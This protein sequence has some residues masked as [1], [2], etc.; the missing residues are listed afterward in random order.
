[1]SSLRAARLLVAAL[2]LGP[3]VAAC[4]GAANSH[5]VITQSTDAPLDKDHK[6]H[7][8]PGT[9]ATITVSIRNT[10]RDPARGVSIRNVLPSGFHYYSLTTLGGNAIRTS[11][12]DPALKGD[13]EWGVFTIPAGNTSRE[14]QLVVSFKV[15]AAS[16]P[17]EY[18]NAVKISSPL[19]VDLEKG[20]PV[21]LIVEPRPSLNLTTASAVAQATS[22]GTV[23]YLVSVE[24]VGSAVANGVTVSATLPSGFLYLTTNGYEGNSSR[25][26]YV[27]PP[28]S[29]VLPV[30]SSWNV[31]PMNNN[32][33]GLL[34]I[35]FQTRILPAVQ[36]GVYSLT[37]AVT[38]SGDIPMQ[39]SG[40]VAP[41]T[42]G[43]GTT[44]PLSMRVQASA[45]YVSQSGTVSYSIAVENNSTEAAR[46]ITVTDSLP[47]GFTYQATDRVDVAGKTVGSR[48]Q[49]Q[50][51]T[52][53]PRWGPFTLPAGGFSGS[54]IVIWFTARVSGASLGPHVNV[55]SG[56]SSNAQITGASDQSPVI[57]TP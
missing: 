22:G 7:L 56:T 26:G 19:P 55:V 18:T 27:D 15:Q 47:E 4:A 17:G 5:L 20:D 39:T 42:V 3:S 49:P 25:I 21:V 34:R 44:V 12:Q 8:A 46:D 23:T 38:G 31:P 29:S 11:F 10:G 50:V 37:T 24:N 13:P 16:K 9:F 57:V 54:T 28:G 48:L 51:G 14:S 30:W 36:P 43:K 41:V 40:E 6:G 33:P 53:T 2:L 35:V 32:V 52:S 1:M 45:I